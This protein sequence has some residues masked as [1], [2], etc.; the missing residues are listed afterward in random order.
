MIHDTTSIRYYFYT[1]QYRYRYRYKSI[2][3]GYAVVESQIAYGEAVAV[4]LTISAMTF[5]KVVHPP[6]G[7]YA[8]LYVNKGMG[9]KGIFFPGLVGGIVIV[10]VQKII[11][12]TIKPMLTKITTTDPAP[13]AD[14][15]KK[16]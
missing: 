14:D 8:F 1:I 11:N 7:A 5:F 2:H 15:K 3:I 10:I 13:A 9:W 4:A 12:G 16:K 6:A